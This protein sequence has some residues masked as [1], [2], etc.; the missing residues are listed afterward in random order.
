MKKENQRLF[1]LCGEAFSGKSTLAKKISESYGA[2][3]IGRDEIYFALDDILA[4]ENTPDK[5]DS[6]LWNNLW[7]IAIRGVKNQLSLGNSVVFDDTCLHLRQREELRSI[8]KELGIISNF[9]YFDISAETLKKRREENKITK[10]RHDVPSGW[11]EEDAQLFERPTESE[12][13][14]I[15][16]ENTTIDELLKKLKD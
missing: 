12:N 3:I 7:P 14:V 10:D 8:A 1:I 15:Y 9:I 5:D 13:S 2:K 4:L 11:L 6:S 16:T